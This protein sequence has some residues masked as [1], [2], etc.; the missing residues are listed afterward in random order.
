MDMKKEVIEIYREKSSYCTH[1]HNVY[2]VVTTIDIIFLKIWWKTFINFLLSPF[3]TYR[4]EDFRK[5]YNI[6][7]SKPNFQYY[8]EESRFWGYKG[9]AEIQKEIAESW[10]KESVEASEI[11][12]TEIMKYKYK[13][14]LW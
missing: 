12:K 13:N 8:T 4:I 6:T 10:F 9:H 3:T 2:E 11:V 1:L 14:R 5:L 7:V